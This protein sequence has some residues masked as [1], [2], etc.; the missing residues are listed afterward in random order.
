[1]LDSYGGN[2][3]T[4]GSYRLGV[5]G[6]GADIDT[7]CVVPNHIRRDPDF[8]GTLVD[9]LAKRPEVT[10][11]TPVIEAFVPEIQMVF[12]GIHTD[13]AMAALN[14]SAIPA[15]LDLSDNK[16]LRDLDPE[17]IRSING[18]RVTDRILTLVPDVKVFRLALYA[19]KLWA[20]RR[21]IY[22]NAMG[23]LGGVS[24]AMLV[25]RVC[26]FYPK[27]CVA[28]IV[29]KFMMV[30]SNWKWPTPVLLLNVETE[31]FGSFTV[32]D[33]RFNPG[34]RRALM[35]IITPAFPSQNS[36]HNVSASTLKVMRNEFDRGCVIAMQIDEGKATWS[37]LFD[38]SDFFSRHR[39][40]LQIDAIS[41]TEDKFHKWIGLVEGRGMR[42]LVM[43][44]ERILG[45]EIACPWPK[46]YERDFPKLSAMAE[47]GTATAEVAEASQ[48]DIAEL[49][50]PEKEKYCNSY[51]IGIELDSTA[52]GPF[53]FYSVVHNVQERLAQQQGEDPDGK[54]EF[55]HVKRSNLPEW[56][57]EMGESRPIK[58]PKRKVDQAERMK[59]K[60]KVAAANAGT[61]KPAENGAV[62]SGV[63]SDTPS[64]AADQPSSAAEGVA[65]AATAE[66]TDDVKGVAKGE[67]KRT[68]KQDE[69]EGHEDE[70]P[71]SPAGPPIQT[72][73]KVEQEK[74]E[75][76]YKD[77]Q[78]KLPQ[79]TSVPKKSEIKLRLN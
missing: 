4:F 41:P 69:L 39:H 22:N 56:L 54:L 70:E 8:F 25:A 53:D 50:K 60:R 19:I 65:E 40:F 31:N 67:D 5:H 12:E 72:T 64:I 74:N 20:K 55:T 49:E 52:K 79:T 43:G 61:I 30:M 73:R 57:F 62:S 59:K 63:V 27:G 66:G 33:P 18:R 10:Q 71:I 23:F 29:L 75:L 45:V 77:S 37:D 7:L 21:G 58:K 15:T 9:M 42:Y 1:M 51:F 38:K 24:W 36:T 78:I 3:Y 32:W 68:E 48:A 2:I 47:K 44:L 17:S 11:L 6:R 46:G 14:M 16:L 76:T 28:T 26:Q 34:D 13:L 35:P